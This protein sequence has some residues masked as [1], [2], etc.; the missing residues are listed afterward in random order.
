M[1]ET[2]YNDEMEAEILRLEAKQRATLAGHPEWDNA[3]NRCGC[4]LESLQDTHCTV[5]TDLKQ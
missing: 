5:C 3:C 2:A 1:F 4:R